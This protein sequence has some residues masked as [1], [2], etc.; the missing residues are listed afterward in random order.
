MKISTS[1][2]IA[3]IISLSLP[4]TGLSQDAAAEKKQATVNEKCPIT[5]KAVNPKCTLD[6]EG[7]TYGFCSGECRVKFKEDR[8]NSLY[9]KIGGKAAVNAAVDLFTPRFW[10]TSV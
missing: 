1:S 4:L 2:I 5:G 9:Q 7:E 6:Y 10:R 8:A 3:L